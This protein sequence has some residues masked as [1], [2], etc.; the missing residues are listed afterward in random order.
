M[1]NWKTYTV[2]VPPFVR[3]G[4]TFPVLAGGNVV[5]VYCPP[6]IAEGSAVYFRIAENNVCTSPSCYVGEPTIVAAVSEL[7]QETVDEAQTA[8]LG[9]W[10]TFD[11]F[12]A[13]FFIL[14]CA[15]QPVLFQFLSDSC[16]AINPKTSAPIKNL[17]YDIFGGLGSGIPCSDGGNDFWYAH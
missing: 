7:P 14:T 13:I 4:E 17:M 8:C 10:L 11:I 15:L 16:G 3:S 2:V 1:N 9:I 6:G 5:N 12:A